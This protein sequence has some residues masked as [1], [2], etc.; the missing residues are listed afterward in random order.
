[1]LS[2]ILLTMSELSTEELAVRMRPIPLRVSVFEAAAHIFRLLS[3]S[4]C[5]RIHFKR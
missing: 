4:P 1:V 2:G 5:V 3:K